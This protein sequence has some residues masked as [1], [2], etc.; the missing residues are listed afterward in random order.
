MGTKLIIKGADFSNEGL[1]DNPFWYNSFSNEILQKNRIGATGSNVNIGVGQD[2]S[3]SGI[4]ALNKP[5]NIIRIY[6]SHNTL[7]GTYSIYKMSVG[8]SKSKE[9]TSIKDFTFS[10]DDI[11]NGYK[12][13]LLDSSVTI[14]SSTE[15]L[16]VGKLGSAGGEYLPVCYVSVDSDVNSI[17]LRSQ[18]TVQSSSVSILYLVQY[19]LL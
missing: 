11:S 3:T 15:T 1:K 2:F 4:N 13:I 12:E 8:D 18:S 17:F 7:T 6:M 9:F 19:G 10:A 14:T 5:I 16:A